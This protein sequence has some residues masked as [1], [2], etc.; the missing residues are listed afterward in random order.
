[1]KHQVKKYCD[2]IDNFFDD[3]YLNIFYWE[4]IKE[5]PVSAS[6]TTNSFGYPYRSGKNNLIL[7]KT[8]FLRGA[9]NNDIYTANPIAD[10]NNI[11]VFDSLFPKFSFMWQGIEQNF[12]GP[13]FLTNIQVNLQM[14][15]MDSDIHTDSQISEAKTCLI[16]PNNKWEKEWGGDLLL[17]NTE[18]TEIVETI[19]IKPGRIVIFNSTVPHIGLPPLVKTVTRY[20]IAFRYYPISY[21]LGENKKEQYVDNTTNNIAYK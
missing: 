6:L 17:Y 16:Y 12:V 10:I 13:T 7:G 11:R 1:M 9:N 21:V 18:Q 8:I 2:V 19:N 20:S 5:M 14:I 3:E 15:G 4:T